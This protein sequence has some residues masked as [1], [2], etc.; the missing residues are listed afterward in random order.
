MLTPSE[1]GVI[2]TFEW[3]AVDRNNEKRLCEGS[4]EANELCESGWI[5]KAVNVRG[6]CLRPIMWKDVDRVVRRIISGCRGHEPAH[7][8][9][10]S[11]NCTLLKVPN[12]L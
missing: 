12:F 10:C 3:N 6:A 8:V 9:I 11:N 2:N 1:E 4:Y 7:V 5:A